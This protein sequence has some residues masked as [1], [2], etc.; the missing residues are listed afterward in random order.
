[1]RIALLS[2][3]AALF[4]CAG[5]VPEAA[6]A[7]RLENGSFEAGR[8]P[9][10]DFQGP[11]KPF[12]GTFYLSDRY[13]VD[14]T[15]SLRLM[16]DSKDF[17][18][19]RNGVGIAG[20][21][22]DVVSDPFPR[23]LSGSYRVDAWHRGTPNQ[24]VQVVVMA[25]LPTNFPELGRTAIQM[26]FVLTGIEE[27]PFEISNRR[28]SF[29]GPYQ[30]RLARWVPFEIDLHEAFLEHWG[31]V[32]EGHEGVRFFAEARFDGYRR[33]REGARLGVRWE[34][35]EAVA[36]FYPVARR[37]FDIV[38]PHPPFVDPTPGLGARQVREPRQGEV[39]SL[40]GQRLF[41]DEVHQS[42]RYRSSK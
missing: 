39:E 11:R 16:L 12:W 41:D 15:S 21:A 14:G 22:Q 13:A 6:P 40:A 31:K 36:G 32:P 4:S 9:W 29:L 20:A 35:L 37:R 18:S 8:E 30:P 42:P 34:R 19:A 17:M 10:Y 5:P 7:N 28:F 33:G 25:M 3:L 27:P 23:R 2:V 24:Y 38:D 26:A 1:M